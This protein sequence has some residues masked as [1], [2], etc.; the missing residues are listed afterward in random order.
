MIVVDT[1]V[2]SEL[3]RSSPS[4]IVREW[5]LQQD[6]REL[7]ISSITVAEILYGIERLPSGKRRKE[8]SDVA[9]GIFGGFTEQ[10]LPFDVLAATHYS[11]IVASREEQGN[12]IGG[13][14]AQIAAICRSCEAQLATR[15]EKDF[16]GV[17]VSIINPWI[18]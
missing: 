1:N 9:L 8:L 7:R 2:V 16:V 17:G 3:M 10:I 15:N 14:D 11:M 6:S 5:F 4:E 18:K 12:P 13:F